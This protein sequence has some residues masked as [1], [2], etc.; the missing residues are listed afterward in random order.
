MDLL[1]I[2]SYVDQKYYQIYRNDDS[3]LNPFSMVKAGIK[4][5]VITE[6]E[7]RRYVFSGIVTLECK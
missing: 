3:A 5:A 6:N 7:N 1:K 2:V 4:E